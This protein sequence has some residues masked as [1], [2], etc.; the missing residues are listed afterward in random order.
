MSSIA[1]FIYINLL[2]V[3]R[4]QQQLYLLRA[5]KLNQWSPVRIQGYR[6]E[7]RPSRRIGASTKT[8]DIM[9]KYHGIYD[10]YIYIYICMSIL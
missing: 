4:N 2:E 10:I 5:N 7:V 8:E 9:G 6:L 3:T 1:I